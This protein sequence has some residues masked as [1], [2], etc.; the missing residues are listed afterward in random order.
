MG[1]KKDIDELPVRICKLP[2]PKS[3][4]LLSKTF[5][6]RGFHFVRHN[7]LWIGVA[8]IIG[9]IG[10]NYIAIRIQMSGWLTGANVISWSD[11]LFIIVIGGVVLSFIVLFVK[12]YTAPQSGH[13][14]ITRSK[15]DSVDG[16]G[17]I[18]GYD[19]SY[20]AL[21]PGKIGLPVQ[22]STERKRTDTF[23]D[24]A[25]DRI[26]EVEKKKKKQR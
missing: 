9:L 13:V 26:S 19:Y 25:K 8:S 12:S 16:F 20:T 10:F 14:R 5:F 6:T 18:R 22:Q 15:S 23:R 21:R 7:L 11:I 1:I 3:D 17:A 4:R 24:G 2:A